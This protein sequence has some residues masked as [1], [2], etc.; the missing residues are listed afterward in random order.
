MSDAPEQIFAEPTLDQQSPPA[1]KPVGGRIFFSGAE[2]SLVEEDEINLTSVGVDIGSSTAHLLF[3]R[4]TLERLDTRYVVVE[5]EVIH[6]SDILLTPYLENSDI[7]TERLQAFIDKQYWQAGIDR[8]EVDSGALILT[9]VAVRRRNARAIGELFAAEAGKF[10]AVS[11]GDRLETVMAAH[12]SGAVE[13][14]RDGRRIVN[15]DVGGGTTKIAVCEAGEITHLTAVEAGARLV[16]TDAARR[17]SRLERF[18]AEALDRDATEPDTPAAALGQVLPAARRDGLA[19]DMARRIMA[20]LRGRAEADHHRLPPLP[21]GL[22]FDG[23]IVSGGVSE[24]FY[25]RATESY[26]DLGPEM[27]RTLRQCLSEAGAAILPHRDGIRATVVGASQYSVQLSGSTVYLDPIEVL[28]LRNVAALRPVLPLA[29]EVID[30]GAVARA[31]AE[32]LALR[33]AGEAGDAINAEPVAIAL[34]WE[35]S[36]SYGRLDGLARGLCQGLAP[37]LDAG[38]PLVIVSDSDIGG[39]LGMHCRENG[40]TDNAIVSIDGIALSTFDF[41]D[42][43]EV[44]RTTGSVPVVVK[45]LIFPGEGTSSSKDPDA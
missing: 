14:S 32:A 42:I 23:V 9:G 6:A 17:I 25:G 7:D 26:G 43:G 44:I 36:A 24:F 15:I 10:V 38:H 45:S 3:S 33:E 1:E 20:A 27:A 28:P 37:V 5:R 11:A 16:V 19:R 29:D 40:L 2:R 13:A 21:E 22:D 35:G 34:A 31:V 4:I 41:I 12:G 8:A 30:P 18:G 39:L